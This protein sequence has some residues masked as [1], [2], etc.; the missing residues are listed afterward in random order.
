[1]FNQPTTNQQQQPVRLWG[2][3]ISGTG[4]RLSIAPWDFLERKNRTVEILK[5][6]IQVE[7][8]S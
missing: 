4:S 6:F 1:V 2:L 7:I 8:D 3:S 5:E